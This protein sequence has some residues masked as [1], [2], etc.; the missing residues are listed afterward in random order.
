M[1]EVPGSIGSNKSPVN[2]GGAFFGLRVPSVE[3][4]NNEKLLSASL[5]VVL[6]HPWKEI[7]IFE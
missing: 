6:T 7:S 2:G 4:L 3:H 1:G 5:F